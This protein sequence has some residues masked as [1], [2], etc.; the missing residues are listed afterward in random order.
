MRGTSRR[1]SAEPTPTP[2]W[3]LCAGSGGSRDQMTSPTSVAVSTI[4]SSISMTPSLVTSVSS[5]RPQLLL[6]E[7]HR[8]LRLPHDGVHPPPRP[9][10]LP[11]HKVQAED[12]GPDTRV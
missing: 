4:L 6:G 8:D 3:R 10:H 7:E 1:S 5:L 9:R 11:R 12:R 2:P